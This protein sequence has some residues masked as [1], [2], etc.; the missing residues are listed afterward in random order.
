MRK[1]LIAPEPIEISIKENPSRGIFLW[2]FPVVNQPSEFHWNWS[3][4]GFYFKPIPSQPTRTNGMKWIVRVGYSSEA[5]NIE[6]K[7]EI[8]V[9]AVTNL[10]AD[11]M[12]RH[13]SSYEKVPLLS[14]ADWIL[15]A[16]PISVKLPIDSRRKLPSGLLGSNEQFPC[17]A[18]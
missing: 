4:P 9:A 3:S 12:K 6:I 10:N 8:S 13:H 1:F 7:P 15:S 17:R 16:K 11:K 5:A 18:P 2:D 14:A